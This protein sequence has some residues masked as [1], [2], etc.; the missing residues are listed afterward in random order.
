MQVQEEQYHLKQ[1]VL[2]GCQSA[3]LM[4]KIIAPIQH[5]QVIMVF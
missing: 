1:T 5:A 2:V 3:I 4:V